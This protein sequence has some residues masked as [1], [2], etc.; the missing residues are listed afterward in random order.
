MYKKKIGKCKQH[1]AQ[2]R[3]EIFVNTCSDFLVEKTLLNWSMKIGQVMINLRKKP[4]EHISQLEKGLV[5]L[6]RKRDG[7]KTSTVRFHLSLHF[8]SSSLQTSHV[9]NATVISGL[10][11]L[12]ATQIYQ[13][14][15]RNGFVKLLLL[16]LCC[17]S[18][19]LGSLSKY[20]QSKSF[21]LELLLQMY[22]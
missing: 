11:V 15:Y 12:T 4:S 1:G 8:F 22:V 16:Y 20:S 19:T 5:T 18:G 10:F 7:S 6:Q 17:F 14:C 9:L 3:C 13:L 21:I 2:S